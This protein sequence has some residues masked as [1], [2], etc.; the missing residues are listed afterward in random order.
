MWERGLSYEYSGISFLGLG[1]GQ[2]LVVWKVW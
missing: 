2:F 1:L